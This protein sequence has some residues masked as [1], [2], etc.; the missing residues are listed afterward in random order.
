M[1]LSNRVT[2]V[3]NDEY[4][5]AVVD[6]VLNSNVLFARLFMRESKVWSGTQMIMPIQVSKPVTGGSFEGTGNFETALQDTRRKQTFDVAA[7]YQNVSLSGIE[8]SLNATDAQVL[9]LV[10]VSMEEAQNALT[11]SVGDQFYGTGP[12][13]DFQGLGAIVDDGTNSA[14]YGGLSRSTYP[15]LNSVVQAASGGVLS[16]G[17]MA[18]VS[19][20]VSAASSAKQ[21]PTVILTTEVVWD[22]YESLLTPTVQANYE[23]SGRP[24]ITA[25]SKPGATIKGQTSLTGNGGFEVLTYRA[26]PV[27]ADEKCPTGEMYFLNENYL[28]WYSLKGKNLQTYTTKGNV[29]DGVNSEYDRAYPIQW[30]GLKDPEAQYAQ[31]GQFIL[32]GNLLSASTRRHGKATG[33]TTV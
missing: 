33:I 1:T 23:A 29:I 7:Y 2:T 6:G 21:T 19:R 24:Q 30:T 26:R 32:L 10:N 16:L 27:V 3:T 12:G 18:T 20:G 28:H 5:K 8:V 13:T 14:S 15:L 11:D 4:A 31:V 9:S 22:L 17:L 25:F